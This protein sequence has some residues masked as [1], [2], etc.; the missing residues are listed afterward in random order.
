MFEVCQNANKD[1]TA[2]IRSAVQVYE[3]FHGLRQP[4]ELEFVEATA[5]VLD[6]LFDAR[7]FPWPQRIA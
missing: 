5:R 7:Q 2:V 1:H 6:R 3:V 4:C